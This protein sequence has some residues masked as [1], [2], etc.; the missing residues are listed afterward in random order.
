MNRSS[1]IFETIDLGLI[2]L[3]R[4]LNVMGWNRWMEIHS[5]IPAVD[6]VGK[7]IMEK[8]PNLGDN[9][10]RRLFK[11]VL[12]FGSYAY[13][14]QKLHHY[15]IP[16]KNQ[17]SSVASMPFM[18]QSSTAAPLRD[19]NGLITGLFITVH[20]VTEYAIYEQKLL[21]MTKIDALTRLYN[22]SFLDR[23]LSEELERSRRFGCTFSVIMIDIDH[24]KRIN[25]TRGH[26]CGDHTLRRVAAIL[27]QVV[28][29]VDFVGRYGGEEFCC[30]LPETCSADACIL[31]E[32]LRVEVAAEVF[33]HGTE[34]YG[35]TISLGVAE[36]GDKAKN[37][38]TLVGLADAALYRAKSEGR[39]RVICAGSPPVAPAAVEAER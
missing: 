27:Q 16:L 6:I 33:T 30:V 20:D 18:Q 38:E 2:V 3:D 34:Q 14:S 29:T 10:Y 13:F 17:H 11:S 15:L 35:I 5:E 8:Y 9:K 4:E 23:R 21:E 37:L 39:D 36:Y 1:Q 31:A 28:R 25:D 26:L 19:Q 32:R 24:F 22:R 7:P 12:L